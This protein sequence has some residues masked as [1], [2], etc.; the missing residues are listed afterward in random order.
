MN[1]FSVFENWEKAKKLQKAGKKEELRNSL[2]EMLGS[3][4]LFREKHPDAIDMENIKI[5]L[6][7]E[8]IWNCLENEGLML[9]ETNCKGNFNFSF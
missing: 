9:D 5:D 8:R 4:I 7:M 6:W 3:I 2:D 1:K